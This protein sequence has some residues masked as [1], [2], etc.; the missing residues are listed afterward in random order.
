MKA[1]ISKSITAAVESRTRMFY[2][3]LVRATPGFAKS[4]GTDNGYADMTGLIVDH[5]A[6][7]FATTI[8][9]LWLNWAGKKFDVSLGRQRINWGLNLVWN[10]ND[11][12]NA[13]NFLDFD[14]E[15][16]PGTDAVRVQ[17][18]TGD[19]SS[20]ELAARF[21]MNPDSTVVAGMYKFNKWEYDF[22]VLGGVFYSDLTIGFGWAGNLKNA[23]FKGEAS[24]FHPRSYFS[25]TSGVLNTSLS[26][27]YTL[28]KSVYV[29]GSILYNSKGITNLDNIGSVQSQEFFARISAKYLMPTQFSF[30][31]QLSAPLS[32]LLHVDFA[33]I[34]GAGLNLL[35]AIPSLT[36]S[37]KQNWDIAL[38]GQIFFIEYADKFGNAGNYIFLRLKWSY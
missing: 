34:Y 31:G 1:Y 8:D 9:R 35:I 6:F 29:N 23:G 11:L 28:K 10:P 21:S 3:E 38:I 13:Y 24:Y 4:I 22:Q 27:D 33:A 18:Y 17:Y 2:G 32:P 36:Y 15:E 19:M 7:A 16:K 20:V 25:D 5:E 30:F 26:I 12:F 37:L 14:Y